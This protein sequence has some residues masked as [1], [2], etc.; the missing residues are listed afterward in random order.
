MICLSGI[1]SLPWLVCPTGSLAGC[2]VSPEGTILY[3][4]AVWYKEV[5]EHE[6]ELGGHDDQV[7]G[8]IAYSSNGGLDVGYVGGA[9]VNGNASSWM[10]GPLVI[11]RDDY[12]NG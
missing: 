12:F 5:T 10:L 2:A 7:E 3:W 9:D 4:C 8:S 1:N 6:D 11:R